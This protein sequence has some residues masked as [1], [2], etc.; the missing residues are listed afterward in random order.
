MDK[1]KMKKAVEKGHP[2]FV[3]E[4]AGMSVEAL[5]AKLL[6]LAKYREQ[7]IDGK[8]ND[9]KLKEVSE[10]KSE[11]EAPYRDALKAIGLKS[12]YVVELIKEKGGQA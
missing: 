6:G 4:V 8:A 7:T 1:S 5:E 11:F 3:D 9:A 10:M 12:A 2:S